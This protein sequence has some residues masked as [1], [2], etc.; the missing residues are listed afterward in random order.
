MTSLMDVRQCC[1]MLGV[2]PDDHRYLLLSDNTG[3]VY[4]DNVS[5]IT[6]TVSRNMVSYAC[7]L[8]TFNYLTTS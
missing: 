8:E 7:K 2:L 4:G 5:S 6:S 3:E 1:F